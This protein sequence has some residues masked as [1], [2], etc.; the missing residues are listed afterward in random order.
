MKYVDAELAGWWRSMAGNRARPNG[1]TESFRQLASL[2]KVV[3]AAGARMLVGT[4]A[5]NPLMIPGFSVHEEMDMLVKHA[6]FTRL[7]VLMAATRNA[8]E[9]LGDSTAGRVEVGARGDLLLV[10]GNPLEDLETLRSPAGVLVNGHWLDRA[11][12]TSGLSRAV[13]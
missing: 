9:F 10:D 7:D 13:R 3:R 11:A 4:D 1:M 8:A 6:G 12:L 2:T 5:S